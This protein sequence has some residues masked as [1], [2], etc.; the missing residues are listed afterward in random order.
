MQAH[1]MEGENDQSQHKDDITHNILNPL[2]EEIFPRVIKPR[3]K[4]PKYWQAWVLMM[5]VW[6]F[7]PLSLLYTIWFFQFRSRPASLPQTILAAYTVTEI[8]FALYHLHLS[9]LVQ[10]PGRPSPLSL[11]SRNNLFLRLLRAGIAYPAPPLPMRLDDCVEYAEGMYRTGHLTAAQLHRVREW[12]SEGAMVARQETTGRMTQDEKKVLDSFREKVPG[13]R[14]ERLKGEVENGV[15]E[16]QSGEILLEEYDRRVVEFR[17]RL[18][19]WFHHAPWDT[20]PRHNVLMWLAWTCFGLPIEKAQA[21]PTWDKF[22]DSTLELLEE[23]TGSHFRDGYDRK[24]KVMRLT[25]DPVNVQLRP[26]FLYALTNLTNWYLRDFQYPSEGLHLYREGEIDYLLRIPNGWT[27]TKGRHL[28]NNM[29]VIYLH[30]LG[31]GALQNHFLV[32]HLIKSLPTHPIVIPLAYHTSQAFFHPRYLKPWSREE[33]VGS[34]KG[35]CK[36]W[37]FWDEDS[38]GG[39]VSLMSHSNGSVGHS[40]ILKDCPALARRNVFVDPVVFCLWEGDV[41][42]NFCY[43]KPSTA[44]ELLLQYFVASE[45]GIANYIQRHFDWAENTLFID[46]IPHAGDPTKT[47]FFLGG[48]DMIIDAMR[49]RKYLERNGIKEGLHWDPQGGHGDGLVGEARDRV[50]MFTGT[51]S[52]MGWEGWLRSGRRRHSLGQDAS[53]RLGSD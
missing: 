32:R 15:E 26:L 2:P 25:L 28:T 35:I 37:Q 13:E 43:R 16:G 9:R 4:S 41:C 20:I 47:A 52:T 21:N 18:R 27:P 14:E 12:R 3:K 5:F 1:Q 42:Y 45:A 17:E 22:L 46:E 40:W 11:E 38:E 31:F 36:R 29:P 33:M 50:V 8:V 19:T 30:G 10:A 34:I 44:M 39:G 7:T 6:S 24:V 23:T 53:A 48:K 51:G 49:V